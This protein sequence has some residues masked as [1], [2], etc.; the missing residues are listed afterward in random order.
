MR[1]HRR[2]HDYLHSER[3]VDE[4]AQ[5]IAQQK[6]RVAELKRKGRSAQEAEAVLRRFERLLLEIENPRF[7]MLDLMRSDRAG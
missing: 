1:H 6:A 4:A 3:F 5:R 2:E 7:L